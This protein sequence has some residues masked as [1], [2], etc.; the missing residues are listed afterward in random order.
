MSKVIIIGA[1]PAGLL[2]ANYLLA[3]NHYQVEIY[4]RRPDFRRSAASNQRTFPISLQSRGL[5]AIR[6]IPGLEAALAQDGV[7]SHSGLLHRKRGKPRRIKRKM[8]LLIVDR[9]QLTQVL[10][11]HL[12][13]Q[14]DPGALTV[15]FDCACTSID[16]ESQTVTLHPTE[17][18]PFTARFDYLAGAD[19]VRSQVRD[20]LVAK[21]FMQ[22]E[23][24]TVPD[25]YKS[26]FVRR[27]H[28]DPAIALAEGPIHSWSLGPNIRIV[29]APQSG[30]WLH[31]VMVFPFGK[32]PLAGCADATA[33]QKYL[34]AKCPALAQLMTLEDAEALRQRPVSQILTVR[35]DRMHVGDRILLIGDA[36][37]AVSP[38]IG[39]GCNASLQD[40]Q[41]FAQLL[42]HYHD[43]WA[44]ALQAF[45]AQRLPEA[46]ALRDLSD[47][48]FPRSKLMV[49][50][51]V[52]RV[53]LGRKLRPWLPQLGKPLPMELAIESELPY[54][55]VLEQTQGWVNRVRRSMPSQKTEHSV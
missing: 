19:G 41:V 18:D 3:R 8:P 1:G 49:L 38:A 39:Q 55:Q 52:W 51:F 20:T 15:R 23:Q 45:T 31:G 17:G 26:L 46:H 28:Q 6:V 42:D 44:Q 27:V 50:E 35:C 7:W 12:L 10:L 14:Y 5:N 54:T 37:H 25:A 22:C 30:D 4:D 32:N 21:S 43:D 36:V 34:Q 29:M 33:V 48:S 47:Y 13:N 16:P 24:S 9:N 40:V 53:T 2:L 11:Q